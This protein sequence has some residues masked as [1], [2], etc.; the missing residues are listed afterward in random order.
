MPAQ[1]KAIEYYLPDNI[2]NN[3]MIEEIYKPWSSQKVENIIGIRSRHIADMDETASDLGYMAAM[4]L[5]NSGVVSPAQID[6]LL[7][8]TET[9]DYPL[10]PSACILQ[11]R[12]NLPKTTG[13]L[14]YNLGCSGFIYGLGLSQGLIVTE[15]AKNVLLITSDTYSKHIHSD[16]KSVRTLFG[17]GGA[18]TLISISDEDCIGPF[19]HGTDGSGFSNLIVT[20][21]TARSPNFIRN[22]NL[23]KKTKFPDNLYMNGSALFNFTIQTVPHTVEKF[24]QKINSKLEDVD[25]FVFHQANKYILEHLRQKIGIP[26]E[27]FFVDISDTGNTVSASI[28]IA[29]K[30]ASTL[31]LIKKGDRILTIGFGV[32]YSW[33]I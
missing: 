2:L 11:D 3:E 13:A 32:G 16:D 29:L 27:R 17:D 18:A 28:P 14:D 24:L 9:P 23:S 19:Q 7:F 26:K 33:S 12:L 25:F 31:D 20:K 4:K 8:C 21:G 15:Q 22:L 5:F 30:K 10:P 1:I 6:F